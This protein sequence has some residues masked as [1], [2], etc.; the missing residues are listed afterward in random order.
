MNCTT[1]NVHIL[2]RVQAYMEAHLGLIFMQDN[3]TSHRSQ[4]T[5]KNLQT[6][7]IAYIKWPRYPLDLNLKHA[8][9][10]TKT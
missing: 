9:S 4:I 10:W 8:W 5:T 1:Y 2:S 7:G 3:A 6:R